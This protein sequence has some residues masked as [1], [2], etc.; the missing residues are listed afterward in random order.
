MAYI[1][2]RTKH[3][4]RLDFSFPTNSDFVDILGTLKDISFPPL[5]IPGELVVFAAVELLSNSL[6]A[7]RERN[8]SEPVSLS[9]L[10]DKSFLRCEILDQGG[11]F[12]PCQLPYDVSQPVD[13]IDFMSERFVNYRTRRKDGRFGMGLVVVKATSNEFN[14]VFIDKEN[15]ERPW[16]SGQ[17]RGTLIKFGIPIE[18][19][20]NVKGAE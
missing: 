16:Y 8:V 15:K 12:D 13:E 19:T 4:A 5:G 9:F 11:G 17:V 6:R 14:L 1:D 3:Y 2:F 18:E 10:V 7:H 20:E